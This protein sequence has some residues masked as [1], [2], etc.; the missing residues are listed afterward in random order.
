ME[1]RMR[2]YHGVLLLLCAALS[3]YSQ[4]RFEVTVG[5]HM[6][7]QKQT[8]RLLIILS[9]EG[10]PEPRSRIGE[11]DL[12]SARVFG[13]DAVDFGGGS[14]LSVTT[15]DVY[16]PHSPFPCREGG[17]PASPLPPGD[18]FV[19][20]L[21]EFNR[22]LRGSGSPG[23][24]YSAVSRVTI[25]PGSGDALQLELTLSVPPDTLPPETEYVK[26]VRIRSGLLSD[27]HGRPI[28]LRGGILLP[29]DFD[30]EPSRRYPLVI[31]TGGF[32]EPYDQFRNAM[33]EHS[34]FRNA[35]LADSLP[36]MILLFLDGRGPLGDPYQVNSD[37][38]GPY[39]DAVVTELIPYVEKRFR[40]VGRPEA[41]FLRGGSTGGWVS[42]A[43]QVFYPDSFNGA[44]AGSPD[45]V[46]FRA[47]QLVDI[48]RDTNAFVNNSGFERPASRSVNGEVL[49]TM[50]HEV[51]V[52]NVMGR[53]NSYTMSGGQW[54]AW[55][56]VYGPRGGEGKPV[57]LWDQNT[58]S[59]NHEV[60]EHWKRYDLRMVLETNWKT[61][62]PKLRGKIHIWVGDADN[63]FL[64][65]AVHLLDGFLS[66]AD[67]P[68]GGYIRYGPGKGHTGMPLSTYE[69]LREMQE[70]CEGSAH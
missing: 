18:Y 9:G 1:A 23:N 34:R 10:T 14:T 11:T 50:R 12:G 65:N 52:E 45:G 56:A 28:Y 42:L 63:F 44:W 46:D 6:L 30:R 58:G 69:L 70:A 19:Q 27:F 43:L 26:F 32:G 39:G 25:H 21:F 36:R 2:Q 7:P 53:G 68:P 3:A 59:I 20:A 64:N 5:A 35:W 29:R 31:S 40:A 66:H 49:T 48:Y 24:L 38:N 16:Y 61:L 15:S 41:R 51:Q 4:E 22:D 62:G 8:G 17:S 33:G 47:F 13:R 60:T 57:P 67:P 55:N 37:N 54:G